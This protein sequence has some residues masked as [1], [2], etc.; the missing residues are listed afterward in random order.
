MLAAAWASTDSAKLEAFARGLAS[1]LSDAEPAASVEGAGRMGPFTPGVYLVSGSDGSAC[2]TGTLPSEGVG[3]R[4]HVLGIAEFEG[5]AQAAAAPQANSDESL[6]TL[7]DDG[8]TSGSPIARYAAPT[9]VYHRLF[10][11]TVTSTALDN[12]DP[13]ISIYTGGNMDYMNGLEIEGSVIV[14][15]NLTNGRGLVAGRANWGMG[16]TPP[17]NSV[18]LAVGGDYSS[19][20]TTDGNNW[21]RGAVGGRAQIGGRDNRVVPLDSMN[22]INAYGFW[23]TWFISGQDVRSTSNMGHDA[24]LKV[25]IDGKGTIVDYNDYVDRQLQPLSTQLANE[26]P[27]GKVGYARGTDST[28]TVW[29]GVNGRNDDGSMK[30]NGQKDTVT[31]T[32]DEGVITF[33]GDGKKH[34]Q[35]FDLDMDELENQRK[36]L[37]LLQWGVDFENVP[38]DTAIVV[39]VKGSGFRTWNT[40]W[41]YWVNGR[42]VSIGVN[43]QDGA[44]NDFR[45]LASR[46]IWNWT[47]ASYVKYDESHGIMHINST[48][49][50]AQDGK[51]SYEGGSYG[52]SA[53]PGKASNLPGTV[54]APKADVRMRCDQNGRLLVGKDL[55][56]D[57]WEHHNNPWVGFADNN[58]V[59]V[60]AATTASHDGVDVGTDKAVHDSISLRNNGKKYGAVV[61]KAT[62]TLNYSASTD[63]KT[64]DKKP[65]KA[66]GA[67]QVAAGKTASADSPDFTPADLGMKSWQPGRYWFDLSVDEKDLSVTGTARYETSDVGNVARLSGLTDSSEQ[68]TITPTSAPTISTRAMAGDARVGGTQKV[69]DSITIAN[70]DPNRAITVAKV[71]TTLHMKMGNR[72]ASKTVGPVTIPAGGSKTFD[73]ADFAPSD[74]KRG[75]WG[76]T[77]YWFDATVSAADVT[78]PSGAQALSADLVHDGRN[79]KA[80]SFNLTWSK[81]GKDFATK[82]QETFSTAGGT[83]SVH[84]RLNVVNSEA[85]VND[86]SVKVTLNW[87]SS[88]TATKAEA[89]AAKTDTVPAGSAYKDLPGFAPSDLR[90]T[91]WKAGRYWYDVLIPVQEGVGEDIPLD[92]LDDADQESWTAVTPFGLNLA[93][94]AYIGQ[95]GQGRWS[96]EP[97]KGAVFTLTETADASG[98][99]A[100]PGASPRTVTTDANGSAHLLDGTIAPLEVR[101]FKLVETKAPSSYKGTGSGTYWMIK[102]TGTPDGATISATGSNEEAKALLK[103]LD[104]STVTVGNRLEG[105]IMPPMTGGRYDVA[106]AGALTGVVTLG[107]LIAGCVVL[108]R[109]NTSPLDR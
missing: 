14:N 103:G 94:L 101:W 33:T 90:M 68:W 34:T 91:T 66:T 107:L 102:A 60:D 108:R 82:A 10:D 7:D 83:S 17:K 93:K 88:P 37:K 52:S 74:L 59:T 32:G 24:A 18:M 31:V 104:G 23:Y 79:D 95:P 28:E 36:A 27:T 41:R 19:A 75:T 42:K 38:G 73:S 81:G 87:A 46:V 86:L 92:G 1:S 49:N 25:D 2:L 35:V 15:G 65:S 105:N 8:D 71:T 62:V 89:S 78:Y 61:A 58:G 20:S 109:R 4:S 26:T 55:T 54:L 85:L 9:T 44:Y 100:K 13:A 99:T 11:G 72:K 30:Y 96:N 48:H 47:D 16:Y 67:I 51:E 57:V 106:R 29:L 39:N 63:G 50:K 98:S 21:N 45:K 97:V 5:D 76:N 40:G 70:P 77:G 12:E 64:A 3:D 53:S 6:A 69:H 43:Q 80:Q 22:T 56:L 84:D